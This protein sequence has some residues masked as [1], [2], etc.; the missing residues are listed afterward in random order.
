MFDSLFLLVGSEGVVG[1]A[2]YRIEEIPTGNI[3]VI[4]NFHSLKKKH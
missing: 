2:Q 3:N 1:W 4:Y